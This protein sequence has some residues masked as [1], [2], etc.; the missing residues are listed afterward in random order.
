M[1]ARRPAFHQLRSHEPGPAGAILQRWRIAIER[2]DFVEP[3]LD[4]R[5]RGHDRSGAIRRNVLRDAAG[6]DPVHHQPVAERPVRRRQ[7]PLA[8]NSAMGMDQRKGRVI[9]D[10][11]DI[12]EMIG[13]AFE[14]RHDAAQCR[15]A[16]RR[17]DA[18][19]RLHGKR[20][21][22]AERDGRVPRRPRGDAG[23]PVHTRTGQQCIDA[24]VHV[25]EPLLQA[26]HGLAIRRETEMARLDDAGMDRTDR[27]LVKAVAMH[28]QEGIVRRIAPG[29][30]GPRPERCAQLPL[31]MIEPAAAVRSIRRDVTIKIANG[32]F[33]PDGG[34][35]VPTDGGKACP[36]DAERKHARIGGRRRPHR[37]VDRAG[38]AP[39]PDE[40]ALAGPERLADRGPDR[41]IDGKTPP[42][43]MERDGY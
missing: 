35:M 1:S 32:A 33:E 30:R 42:W 14:L 15:G 22:K 25:A 40:I 7:Y 23:R 11:A 31:A 12:A 17:L 21:R 10:R 41:R 18:Q 9:A 20:K 28:G 6:H 3:R 19:R 43:R 39:Q 2:D 8:E 38:I 16:R 29:R 26:R 5:E 13:D 4:F 24:L 34:R 37:H 36:R 27:D